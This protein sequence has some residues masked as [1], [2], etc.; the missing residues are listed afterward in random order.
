MIVKTHYPVIFRGRLINPGVEFE[1][2]AREV[3][4]LRTHAAGVTVVRD[5]PPAPRKKRAP[6][7][8]KTQASGKR[9]GR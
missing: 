6:A 7:R 8:R 3:D 5:D 1:A 2:T 9:K 4:M